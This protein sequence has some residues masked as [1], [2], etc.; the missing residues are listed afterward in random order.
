MLSKTNLHHLY[1][2]PQLSGTMPSSAQQSADETAIQF[3]R[4]ILP[5]RGFYAAMIVKSERQKYNRFASTIPDLWE[6]IKKADKDGNT[7]Y[8]AC[9]SFREG[10]NDPKEVPRAQRRLGRTKSNVLCAKSFWLDIDA[11]PGKPYA[12]WRDAG[13]AL[14]EFCKKSGLPLPLVLSSGARATRLLAS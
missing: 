12:N 4:L 1:A 10:R 3:L 11:G 9:A 13:K 5:D 2:P 8:H 6:I 14:A 7:A